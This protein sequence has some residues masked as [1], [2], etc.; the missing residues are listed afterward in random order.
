MNTTIEQAK[1]ALAA[2]E[3]AYMYELERDSERSEGSGAQE[4]RREEH[5]QTLKENIA[6][7]KRDLEEAKR[8]G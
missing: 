6:Q 5:Q 3:S 4:R 8:V 2:A 7:C 1:A